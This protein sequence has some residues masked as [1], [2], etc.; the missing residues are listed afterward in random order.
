VD[1]SSVPSH[2]ARKR[3]GQN[4]LTQSSAIDRIISSVN[5][6]PD[7]IIIE[8]GPGLGA[9]TQHL[10][11]VCPSLIAIELDRDL[12]K[13]LRQQFPDLHLIE[14]DAL[15]TDFSKLIPA[16]SHKTVKVVGNLPYNIS[17]PLIFHLL[18]FERL[19]NHMYFMLQSEV[20]ERMAAPAGSK[21]YGRLSVM[22]QYACTVEPLFELPPYAFNPA[23]K[24]N[25]TFAAIIPRT[26]LT[27]LIKPEFFETLVSLAFQQRRKT[28]RNALRTIL[29]DNLPEDLL[30]ELN[31]RAEQLSINQFVE[32]ANRLSISSGKNSV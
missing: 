3:F 14:G 8:I 13:H 23:P 26:I 10:Q 12:T 32:L 25:S 1:K 15:K 18:S 4:F 30:T 2:Q 11:A 24:V 19:I 7:D 9:I 6:Q 31:Q 16:P 29:P 17:T 20:I 21:I 22:V 28:L 5:P 27:P